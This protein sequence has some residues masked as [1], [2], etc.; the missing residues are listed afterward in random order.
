MN[1]LVSSERMA[2]IDTA[3]QERFGYPQPILM[4]NAGIK[5]YQL[6]RDR[7]WGKG[8]PGGTVVFAA[9]PG[10]NGGDALV[11]A[12]Q[13]WL[14]GYTDMAVVLL[15][16][17]LSGSPESNR[18]MCERL[19]IPLVSFRRNPDAAAAAF[20]R[21]GWIFDGISGTGISGA[22]RPPYL[23]AATAIND[24][25]ARVVA[26]DVPSGVSDEFEPGFPAVQ[27]TATVTMG[28][29]K[30]CLYTPS[31]RPFGGTIHVVA[32]GFP[33]ALVRDEELPG[34]L[35]AEADLPALVPPVPATTYKNKRGVLAVF[36]GAPGTTG[37]AVLAAEAAARCRAGLVS[38]MADSA[39]YSAFAGQV[40]SVMAK[41]WEPDGEP[42]GFD[43]SAYTGLVIGPGWGATEHK[44][45]W[46][47]AMADTDLPASVDA[48]GLGLLRRVADEEGR[49]S[50]FLEERWVLTPHPGEFSAFAD[51]ERARALT[52]PL[53]HC[54][55]V[56][57]RYGAVV[58][59]KGHVT[60]IVAPDGRHSVVDGMNPAMATGGA[61]DVLAGVIGA[62]LAAGLPAYQAARAGVLVH[63]VAGAR[64]YRRRGWFLSEDL[65]AEV[66]EL[67]RD[68][69]ERRHG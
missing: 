61:G 47:S 23:N 64:A 14:D 43:F 25:G 38:I 66:S 63:A 20:A 29:P 24:S 45:R 16:D 60:W 57:Q 68:V 26:I 28:L 41:P 30:R 33:P 7:Y 19:G 6:V 54:R 31:G 32:L 5:A 69:D 67:L 15:K 27:A 59:L 40:R 51:V 9:G 2:A 48:D 18:L 49:P 53:T 22:L 13:C 58:V 55:R 1:K 56:A 62:L 17:E 39:V 50:G 8:G 42:G 11:M 35:L 36:A 44:Q 3:A 12:R 37:A 34:E 46:L 52:Q 4:E 21:A 65:P 10:N